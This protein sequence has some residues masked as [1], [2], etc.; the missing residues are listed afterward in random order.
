MIVQES[1]MPAIRKRHPEARIV[2]AGGTFDLLHQGHIDYLRASKELGDILVVSIASDTEVRVRKGTGR[3]MLSESER[4]RIV[5]SF[6]YPDY[7]VIRPTI[8]QSWA[9][10]TAH[11]AKL[12]HPDV[13]VVGPPTLPT[14]EGV[15]HLKRVLPGVQIIIDQQP[16]VNSTSEVIRRVRESYRGQQSPA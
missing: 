5:D 2:L 7:T 13:L 3:P 15:E 14:D 6:K 11:I 12:L 8:P 16:K 1:D 10:S 9:D 4:A